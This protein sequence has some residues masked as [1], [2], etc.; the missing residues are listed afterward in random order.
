[1]NFEE[2]KLRKFIFLS[3]QV[4]VKQEKLSFYHWYPNR[5]QK[6]RTQFH[7]CKIK[8]AQNAWIQFFLQKNARAKKARIHFFGIYESPKD[9]NSIFLQA[10]NAQ[11]CAN[12]KC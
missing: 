7:F 1:M 9:T 10:K 8:N 5:L 3:S 4:W 6:K 11:T 12:S 2:K